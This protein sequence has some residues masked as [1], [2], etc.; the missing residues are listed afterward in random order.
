MATKL[1]SIT[2]LKG[3]ENYQGWAIM[4]KAYL[5]RQGLDQAI[6]SPEDDND[7]LQKKAL[8]D[9]TLLCEYGTANHITNCKTG[10]EAWKIL[11]DLYNSDG[12]TNKYILLQQFF[13]TVQSDFESVE[14]YVSK[15]K[16]IL[17]NLT[18]QD[19]MIPEMVNIAW[20]LQNLES[21]FEPFVA[22]VTQ[23]L[24]SN[25]K[26]YTWESLTANLLDE[27]KRLQVANKS[28]KS[29]QQVGFRGKK[30][31]KKSKSI[32]FCK[33]CKLAGHKEDDCYFLHPDKAPK[34]WKTNTNTNTNT[35]THTDK[36]KDGR[37][38]KTPSK[39]K[40]KDTHPRDQ[41]EQQINLLVAAQANKEESDSDSSDTDSDEELEFEDVVLGSTA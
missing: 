31:W 10:F 20:L 21:D 1:G 3:S 29:I 4:A 40:K 5:L 14:A 34:G 23:A 15:I 6:Q 16:S 22:Q 32:A 19:L 7:R 36:V 8:A 9:I 33:Y 11:K 2:K 24:R 12:F 26:A 17:D 28:T 41:R 35:N 30:P 37:V 39:D 13:Q 18:A 38:T 25:P 27:A